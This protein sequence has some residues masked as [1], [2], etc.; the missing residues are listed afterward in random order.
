MKEQRDTNRSFFRLSHKTDLKDTLV[1]QFIYI[2]LS[3]YFSFKLNINFSIFLNIS[4][5]SITIKHVN[6]INDLI[7]RNEYIILKHVKHITF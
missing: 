5:I 1:D 4:K 2:R 6:S 7:I 3:S